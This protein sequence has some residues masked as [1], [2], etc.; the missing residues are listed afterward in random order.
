[1]DCR[2]QR[3]YWKNLEQTLPPEDFL[4]LSSELSQEINSIK[5]LLG[6][7]IKF[8]LAHEFASTD[9]S[10]FID[11]LQRI[12]SIEELETLIS[13]YRKAKESPENFQNFKD[14]LKRRGISCRI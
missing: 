9:L 3:Q 7:D 1:M 4:K 14:I 5:K 8:D 10:Y 6:R 11:D 13:A 2:E 12:E